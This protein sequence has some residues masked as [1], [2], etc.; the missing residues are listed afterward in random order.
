[1]NENNLKYLQDQLFGLGFKDLLNEVLEK[2]I[3]Q[4]K[5]RFSIGISNLQYP[6]KNKR[7]RLSADYVQYELQYSKSQKSDMYFLNGMNVDLQKA[8]L[9]TKESRYFDLK[10]DFGIT[11]LEAYNL[12]SDRAVRKMVPIK[13]EKGEILREENGQ[14]KKQDVWIK[15]DL[16]I[17]DANGQHPLRPF[18]PG[19]KFDL[20]ATLERYGLT[21]IKQDRELNDIVADLHKG[22]PAL[23]RIKV[24]KHLET[25]FIT[26]DPQMKKIQAMT[27]SFVPIPDHDLL[28]TKKKLEER[29]GN[30]ES[31][32]LT[33]DKKKVQSVDRETFEPANTVDNPRQMQVGR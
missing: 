14:P 32:E 10:K 21:K 17:K 20:M 8:G 30:I 2:A 7:D 9:V 18:F 13:D 29:S 33:E 23:A 11:A 4:G 22:N 16:S 6:D 19:Y 15:L 5:D 25:A 31:K 27:L 26:V 24:G 12:L 3:N 28:P 1:M